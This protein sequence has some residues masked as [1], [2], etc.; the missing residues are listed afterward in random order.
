MVHCKAITLRS[1]KIVESLVQNNAKNC[2]G[3]AEREENNVENSGNND[4]T[5]EK[6]LELLEKQ[7]S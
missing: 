2:V 5:T 7:R 1:R 6:V 3:S 4:E